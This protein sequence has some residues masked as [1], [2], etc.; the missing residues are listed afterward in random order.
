MKPGSQSAEGDASRPVRMLALVGFMGAGKTTVGRAL[1]DR[2]QWRFVDLDD[3]VVAREGRA[4][5]QIFAQSGESAF[6]AAE[7][8]A[9]TELLADASWRPCVLALG[10]GAFV[11][12]ENREMLRRAGVS[13]VWLDAPVVELADRCR[14]QNPDRPLARDPNQ[15]RQL[16]E[17]RQTR[18]MEAEVRIETSQRS[19]AEIVEQIASALRLPL[20]KKSAPERSGR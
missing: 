2:L 18:Y 11:Q 8:A 5:P 10:G 1:A 15:F 20:R 12:P 17:A 16:Y 19:I 6:R 14:R 7:T 3:R 4:I 13:A 9:L